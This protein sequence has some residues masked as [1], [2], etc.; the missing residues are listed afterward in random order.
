MQYYLKKIYH[1]EHSKVLK[2]VSELTGLSMKFKKNTKLFLQYTN[3]PTFGT[4]AAS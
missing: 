2:D 3:M 1:R 4:P